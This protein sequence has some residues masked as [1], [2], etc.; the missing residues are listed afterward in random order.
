M[1]SAPFTILDA[2]APARR[3][4][5]KAAPAGDLGLGAADFR[6]MFET[7]VRIRALD[8]RGL[9]SQRQGRIGFYVPSS[10]EEGH[11]VGAAYAL[12]PEDWC[13]PSY[14]VPGVA[15]FRGAPIA[16]M[17][18]NLF[19]NADDFTLGRQMPN[20][21]SF[22]EQNFVSISSPLGTQ[23]PQ[24][25]GAARAMQIRGER[26]VAAVWFGDGTTSEGD[27][28]VAMNFAGV[29]KA[30]C[31]FLC[32]NNQWAISVP[33]HQQTASASI[34]VKA[35]AYG[36]EGVQVDGNDVLAVYKVVRDAVEKARG[37]GGPTLI[38]AVTYRMGP[39]S[40][41]DDPTRYRPA[42]QVEEWKRRDPIARFRKFLLEGGH[43]DGA[44]LDGAV[45]AAKAEVAAAFKEQEAKGPPSLGSL[46]D[47]VFAEI[48]PALE[49]QRRALLEAEGGRFRKDE[50]GAAFP[51]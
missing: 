39:H 10:G 17:V 35:V 23:I 4:A 50:S 1:D 6:R 20:H 25:V 12:L 5:R 15:L 46:F 34:A 30:P 38:E 3:G 31:V 47:D 48:T 51:L 7:M 49:G 43:A 16:R 36:F 32:S 37:G 19:G 44:W 29:W 18:A 45:E 21:Y 8:E 26:N 33:L 13:F 28:H 24:A 9:M 27:F 42:E 40:S 14:R 22:R 11:Q 41:S 2:P